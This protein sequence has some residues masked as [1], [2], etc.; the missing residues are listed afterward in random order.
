MTIAPEQFAPT[1]FHRHRRTSSDELQ[2]QLDS[3]Y[4]LSAM[5][6]PSG[7]GGGGLSACAATHVDPNNNNNNLHAY[8]A[9]ARRYG[10]SSGG[11]LWS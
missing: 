5:H 2:R 4:R 7:G 10:G 11:G 6:V 1:V 3:L 8:D 9:N